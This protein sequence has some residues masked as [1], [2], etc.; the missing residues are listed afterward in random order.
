MK[1]SVLQKFAKITEKHQARDSFLTKLQVQ[2]CN[3]IEKET[4]VQ[5][6]LMGFKNFFNDILFAEHLWEATSAVAALW[7]SEIVVQKCYMKELL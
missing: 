5:V 4:R 2:A 1:K 7:V 6:F 3:I